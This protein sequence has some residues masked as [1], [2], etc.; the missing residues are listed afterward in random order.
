MSA[1]E[2]KDKVIE[3]LKKKKHDLIV[4][5][6]ANPDMVG[7]TGNLKATIK[8]VEIVDKCLGKI[9]EKCLKKKDYF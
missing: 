2:L 6:F 3:N 9:Y 1:F 7:H 4:T 8:A 5:N